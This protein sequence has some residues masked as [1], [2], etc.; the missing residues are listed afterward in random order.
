MACCVVTGQ[1]G[2]IAAALS[3]KS[4]KPLNEI[5]MINLQKELQTQNVR[6]S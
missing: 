4:G 2:G 3:I 5:N 1:G 6:F